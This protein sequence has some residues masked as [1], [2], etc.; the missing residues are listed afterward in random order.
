MT[1]LQIVNPALRGTLGRGTEATGLTNTGNIISGL[2]S[3]FLIIGSIA[4]LLYVIIG[5]VGW[6]ISDGDKG[7][8]EQARNKITQAVL[9]LIILAAAWAMWILLG[10]FLGIDFKNIPFP[11]LSNS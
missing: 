10:K 9:G 2:V 1:L 11:T 6:V 4:A 7:K 3:L 5:G 8:L